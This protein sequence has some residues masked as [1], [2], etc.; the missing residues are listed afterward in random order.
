MESHLITLLQ[1]VEGQEKYVL[2][3]WAVK[4]TFKNHLKIQHRL[5]EVK[6]IK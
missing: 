3:F 4:N 5:K 1:Y 6:M 2:Y